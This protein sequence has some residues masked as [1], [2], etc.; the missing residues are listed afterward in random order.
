MAFLN[1]LLEDR[2]DAVKALFT[3]QRPW[4]RGA[5]D[6]GKW[7][8]VLGELLSFRLNV[9]ILQL[10]DLGSPNFVNS[11]CQNVPLQTLS[12]QHLA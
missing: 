12:Q 1:N 9:L 2:V 5:E 4:P 7:K 6:I 3:T 10:Y 8:G 11:H